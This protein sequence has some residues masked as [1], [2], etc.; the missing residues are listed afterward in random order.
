MALITRVNTLYI[1]SRDGAVGW[2]TALQ[3]GRSRVRFP[4]LALEFFIDIILPAALRH[5]GWLSP[6]RKEY[7]EYFLFGKGGRCV[8]WQTYTFM[9]RLSLNLGASTSWKQRGADKPAQKGN[10]LGSMSGDACEFS[11]IQTRAGIKFFPPARQ[12]AEGN[13]RHSDRNISWFPS[14]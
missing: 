2:G 11:N 10:K 6:N 14:W 8:G 12:D 4:I 1:G 9:C 7:H 3:A 13:S 5:W